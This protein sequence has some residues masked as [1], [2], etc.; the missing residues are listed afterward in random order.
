M[1]LSQLPCTLFQRIEE[2][3][4]EKATLMSHPQV[5]VC[6]NGLESLLIIE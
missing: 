2:N 5:C 6:E 3:G 4:L 1:C